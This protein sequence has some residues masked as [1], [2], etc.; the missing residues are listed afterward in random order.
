MGPFVRQEPK[1]IIIRYRRSPATPVGKAEET[2]RDETVVA[3][4]VR[5]GTGAGLEGDGWL[6]VSIS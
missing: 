1:G 4:Q 6:I 2:V 5:L 3:A